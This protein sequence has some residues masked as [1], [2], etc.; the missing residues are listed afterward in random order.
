[1][2]TYKTLIGEVQQPLSQGETNFKAMHGDINAAIAAAKKV[3]PGVTDQDVVFNGRPRRMDAPTASKEIYKDDDE[4]R[5]DYDKGLK[6]KED[7]EKDKDIKEAKYSAKA[8]RH[9]EDIGKPGKNFDKIAKSAA[10]RYGSEE[11]GKRVAG[12]ILSKMRAK[13][14]HKEEVEA[15]D[16]LK[17]G[18]HVLNNYLRK[19]NPD[20]NSP[21]DNEKRAPGR[22]LALRKKWGKALGVNEPKVSATNEEAELDEKHLTTAEMNKREEIAKAIEKKNPGMP[23]S[24]KMAIATATAK[25][26]AEEKDT[27][28][29]ANHE[30][31]GKDYTSK[32]DK[33]LNMRT[34]EVA[35][36]VKHDCAKHIVHEQWGFGT[37]IPG[38]HTIVETSEGEG[39][40]THYDIMFEHGIEYDVPVEDIKVI[41]SE[42]HGHTPRK[43]M[44]EEADMDYE[45]EM[46]KAE[47][48]AICDKSRKLADMMSDDM[49][50]EAWLQSK[51]SR[52]KDQIDSVYDY[53]MYS[54]RAAS[55]S[56]DVY[57]QAPAMAANYSSFLNKIAEEKMLSAKQKAIAKLDGDPEGI[58]AKDLEK[59]RNSKKSKENVET[60]E[61]RKKIISKTVEEAKEDDEEKADKQSGA[62]LNPITRLNA[63]HQLLRGKIGIKHPIKFDDGKHELDIHA[64]RKALDLHSN[65]KTAAEKE[66][67]Q[68]AYKTHAG[69]QDALKGKFAAPKSKVSLGGSKLVGGL[70]EDADPFTR[71]V[72]RKM[73]LSKDKNGKPF[74]RMSSPGEIA[75]G[76]KSAAD[77][78]TVSEGKE[79]ILV[80]ANMQ[81]DSLDRLNAMSPQASTIKTKLPPTQGN[82]VIGGDEQIYTDIATEETLLN[83]LYMSLSEENRAKFMEKLETQEGT[84]K[85]LE[86]AEEQGL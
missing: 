32:N 57:A 11:A 82:K 28:A 74:W 45:G 38:E 31:F 58:S 80:K 47:L 71:K 55:P 73:L 22:E 60:D 51:I 15:I 5:E 65:A 21:K 69:L 66:K 64:V 33:N 14:M 7:P 16:E 19:T 77:N 67:I 85:L 13:H 44:K 43:S 48:N 20:Y 18:G 49:Q 24:K 75:I 83:N 63:A 78:T 72:E 59:L 53:M 26:V 70:K 46:A 34:K 36:M 30:T 12:A 1:M 29:K 61:H 56:V 9:G 17:H 4:S 81:Q 8:A 10:E 25:K 27:F 2:K 3:V 35:K 37:C 6:M 50:L 79:P 84:L 86:F 23:M 39:Y 40:V 76:K 62:S 42:S 41:I 68:N 54:D 52:A